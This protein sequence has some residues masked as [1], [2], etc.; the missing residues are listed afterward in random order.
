MNA[1]PDAQRGFAMLALLAVIGVGS[2]GV[3][4]AV[5]AFLPP[6]RTRGTTAADNL[7]VAADAQRVAYRRDGAFAADLDALASTAG[8]AGDGAWR[9]DPYGAAQE[10]DLQVSA[11]GATVRSRGVDGRL[12]TADDVTEFV[13]A[14]PLLRAR[15]RPRLRLL[16]AVLLRSE[17]LLD[18]AMTSG[19]Q[20]Q[21]RSALRGYATAQRRLLTSDAATRAALASEMLAHAA[22]ID[23][24]RGAYGLPAMPTSTTGAGGLSSRLGVPDARAVDG[25]GVTFASDPV[26]GWRALGGDG[27][28]GTD[29]DM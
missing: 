3:L 13:A 7:Q 29:D 2:V 10:L 8:L 18:G 16:R 5:Q 22:T 15:Q 23:G 24:L 21:M 4:L 19:E 9:R 1:R 20:A 6:L 25:R 12:G 27:T 11:T 26:L 28:G 14:E 17:F